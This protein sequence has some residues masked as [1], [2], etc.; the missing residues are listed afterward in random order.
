MI[1]ELYLRLIETIFL[2]LAGG[3]TGIIAGAFS[4]YISKLIFGR[5]RLASVPVL[6][7]VLVLVSG[8]LSWAGYFFDNLGTVAWLSSYFLL[9]IAGGYAITGLVTVVYYISTEHIMRLILER[10]DALATLVKQS[11]S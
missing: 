1:S 3:T 6:S 4:P 8:L 7:T 11:K 10:T 5:V 2:F 9:G